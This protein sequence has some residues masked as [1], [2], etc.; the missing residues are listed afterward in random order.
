VELLLFKGANPNGIHGSD[1]TGHVSLI[2]ILIF[3]DRL[4]LSADSDLFKSQD[5][6]TSLG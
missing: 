3:I 4:L 2:I 1:V 6:T 5:K